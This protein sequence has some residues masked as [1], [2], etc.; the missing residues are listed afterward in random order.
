MTA[1]CAASRRSWS[2][3][4]LSRPC[5]RQ[6]YKK[7]IRFPSANSNWNGRI[8]M[9]PF[10]QRVLVTALII[11]GIWIATFFGLRTFHAYR[12]VREHRPPP[13][14]RNE[15]SETNVQL[16]EDWMTVPFI[17]KMYYVPPQVIFDALNIPFEGNKEKSLKQLNEKYF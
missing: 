9:T 10:L 1:R 6:A 2:R 4:A 8:S 13:P 17:A 5:D 7:A 14:F 12:E 3:W 11:F 15:R 16:I